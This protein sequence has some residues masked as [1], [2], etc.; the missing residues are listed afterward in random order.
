MIDGVLWIKSDYAMVGYLNQPSPFD[1]EGWFNTQDRVEVDGEYL[2]ILGRTTD[3]MNIGGQKVYPAEVEDV[4]LSLDKV[5]D[6][7]VYAEPN[8]LLGNIVVAEVRLSEPEAPAALKRR[9]RQGCSAHLASFKVPSRVV[10][11]DSSFY[12]ARHKKVRSGGDRSIGE[13]P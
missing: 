13:L 6:V 2:K 7:R 5:V 8:A 10:E 1:S 3:L 11:V 12:S 4:I 9:V